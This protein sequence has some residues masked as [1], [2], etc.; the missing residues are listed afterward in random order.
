MECIK[1]CD[2]RN[3]TLKAR[4]FCA[5]TDIKGYDEA[6]MAFIMITLALVY[7]ATYLGPWGFL[8]NWANISEVLD[9]Q[10]FSVFAGTIWFTSL[11]GFPALWFLFTWLGKLLAGRKGVPTSRLF[12]K[13]SYLLVPLGLTAWISF[14]LPA[15]LVNI[16]HII[17]S[18][19]D[20]MG[21]GW[22]IFGTAQMQWRP[23]FPES[24]IYIQITL[25]LI[26]LTFSMKRGYEIAQKIYPVIN[27]GIR[28][29]VPLAALCTGITIILLRIFAG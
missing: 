23:L 20:P 21:W 19:S 10:G 26:G 27:E 4:P 29:L 12:L 24:I 3:M 25:L 14:S 16:T 13:Y 6:W 5:D 1:T 18:L 22:D 28:S 9:W 2:N 8:K 7:S 11:I 17:S 15:V